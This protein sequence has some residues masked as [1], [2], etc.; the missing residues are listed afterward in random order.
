MSELI[1]VLEFYVLPAMVIILIYFGWNKY[2]SQRSRQQLKYALEQGIAEPATLHPLIDPNK[3]LGCG[4]CVNACPEGKILGLID[5]K[6]ELISASKCIGHGACQAACPF[7]AI[8][9][10]F[11]TEKRG[12]DIPNVSPDYETNVPGIYI[13]GELG[14]MGLIR[15]AI[16]QGTL[17]IQ[18]LHKKH[19]KT[20]HDFKF[21]VAI[22]GAGPSGLSAALAAIDNKLNYIL[23]EQDTVGGTL[24]HYPR[25][26]VVMT[27]PAVLPVVGKFQFKEASKEKLI[28]F[29]TDAIKTAGV[30]IKMNTRVESVKPLNDGFQIMTNQGKFTSRSVLL[31]IGRRGTPRTL[32]VPGEEQEKVIYRLIDAEQYQGCDILVV[33]GGDSA[34]EAAL[35]LAAQPDTRVTLSYRSQSFS[36]AKQKNLQRITQAEQDKKLTLLMESTVDSIEAKQVTIKTKDGIVKRANDYVLV[37]AGGILPTAFLQDAGIKVET[38]YGTA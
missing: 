6:A 11:G 26:K 8:T 7:D 31:T 36:R 5:N 13:A 34:L 29:W 19:L 2:V 28:E 22:V 21:D 35:D 4:A 18:E 30:R 16:K 24:A 23:L 27:A 38:K 10:V 20:K 3:C 9:L 25:G 33:G 32:G 1:T 15:N 14:G 37:C 12:V 17:A